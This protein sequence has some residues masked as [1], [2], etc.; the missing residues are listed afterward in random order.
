MRK[1]LIVFVVL[2]IGVV[3]AVAQQA[4]R[5]HCNVIPYYGDADLMK[6][7]YRES[8]YYMALEGA[9][10]RRENDSTVRYLRQIDVEKGWK[11][12]LVYLYVRAG[13]GVRL[14][15]NETIM[16]EADDS[17]QWN[18]FLLSPYLLY[19]KPN[20][21]SVEVLKAPKGALLE[22]PI[23]PVGLNG[24]AFLVFKSNPN[25]SDFVLVAD[26]DHTTGTGTL[27]VK[28]SIFTT[29]KKGKYYVEADVL[30]PKGKSVARVGKWVVLRGNSE[31]FVE[32]T[33]TLNDVSPWSAESPT[34]YTLCL[35]MRNADMEEMELVG[36]RFGFR[37][38]KLQDN[39][40]LVNGKPITIK[41]VIY[42]RQND[43]S[44][45]DKDA[46]E[47][48]L[49][50]IKSLNANAVRTAV[51]SPLDEYF[52]QLCDQLGLYVVCD[53]NLLPHSERSRVVATD[54]SFTTLFEHRVDNLYHTLCNRPSIIAWSLGNSPDKGVCMTAAYK[55]LKSLDASRPVLF[56][57]SDNGQYS[58]MI[59]PICP[60]YASFRQTLSRMQEQPFFLLQAVDSLHF[61]RLE[62]M[63]QLVLDRQNLQGGFATT[64]P[65]DSI[66]QEDLK[67]L[68]RPFDIRQLKLSSDEVD[69][70]VYN[71]LDF[72]S[73]GIFSLEYN[74][75]TN[76][77]NSLSGGDLPLVV[78]GGGSDKVSLRLPPFRLEPGEEPFISFEL[79]EKKV[80]KGRTY[81]QKVGMLTF[82]LPT[83]TLSK[84]SYS[85]A[86]ATVMMDTT[87]AVQS[88]K[89]YYLQFDG[90]PDWN[91]VLLHDTCYS[92]NAHAFV[93]EHLVQYEDAVDRQTMMINQVATFY[94]SNDVVIDYF[95]H[96][97]I[98]S[99]RG[100]IP[101]FDFA[102]PQNGEQL[103]FF[104][105]QRQT[106]LKG[107]DA[108]QQGVYQTSLSVFPDAASRS[109]V[110][111]LEILGGK[112]V[113]MGG[114]HFSFVRRGGSLLL[115]PERADSI[116]R[117][118]LH[119]IG[120]E[121][122]SSTR[123]YAT[124]FP[125]RSATLTARQKQKAVQTPQHEV[126][127]SFSRPPSPPYNQGTDTLLSDG[128]YGTLDDLSHGWL[129]F[130]GDPP[131]V[132]VSL[133]QP[134]TVQHVAL[135]FAHNPASWSFA[136]QSVNV[137]VSPDGQQYTDT[138]TAV[139]D[140]DP[141]VEDEQ[142]PR[143]VTL[144]LHPEGR[145][146][147]S[148]RILPSTLGVIPAWHRGKG[149]KPWLLMDEIEIE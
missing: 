64:W 115:T 148:F 28:A 23:L 144:S 68:F 77:R 125:A 20:K 140:F 29:K 74:I 65:L 108:V 36:T 70:V 92:V 91:P 4:E 27:S 147:S 39:Q 80:E 10:H 19:G 67:H 71:R 137:V 35:R 7:S 133:S 11:D 13:H 17:R 146:V 62:S 81:S 18:S 93:I 50:T 47:N 24:D 120:A 143:V 69:Y 94:T 111:W 45:A 102:I 104:G 75:F 129:G 6:Q 63:W 130:A 87:E 31:E 5:P 89:Q 112:Y 78:P 25:I 54:Q 79:K 30:D 122:P 73:F 15:L 113:S 85:P 105:N 109:G 96:P 124:T 40:L 132:E 58:D 2:L 116:L 136:P 49:K 139:V 99:S 114:N 8:P 90:H 128:R 117:V 66:Q 37:T 84:V 135:R 61:D 82:A 56:A 142:S 121:S 97:T 110:R 72:A 32:L 16:G 118:Q 127:V 141:S 76:L 100:V 3:G 38:V 52:Y 101:V 107:D 26:Y 1:S 145:I 9:W 57:A 88:C 55:R 138:L 59:A 22:N 103:Q 46:M 44:V 14:T 42:S 83:K 53:A 60:Q 21:L 12:Y 95:L 106:Y 34:L 131:E 134:I 98:A 43:W 41:G 119:T 86:N 123:L 51:V 149:L 33:R 126:K 48:D